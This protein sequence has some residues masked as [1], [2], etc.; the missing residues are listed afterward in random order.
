MGIIAHIAHNGE[1]A[2]AALK[3]KDVYTV[4]FMDMQMPVMDGLTASSQIRQG[5][6]GSSYTE[7]PIIAM[8]ANALPED[9]QRCLEA[10][11]SHYLAKPI[12]LLELTKILKVL[13]IIE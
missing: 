12:N 1:E 2:L 9:Q 8:T 4:I 3:T 11:M 5:D 7:I 6:A 13:K 10:G